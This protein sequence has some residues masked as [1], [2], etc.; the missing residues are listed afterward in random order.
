MKK[1]DLCSF[2]I[3]YVIIVTVMMFNLITQDNVVNNV[4][5]LQ[6]WEISTNFMRLPC[7]YLTFCRMCYIF[8]FTLPQH[9]K[10]LQ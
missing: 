5:C 7:C 8:P 9:L 2:K 6:T 3:R 10:Q 1:E 4:V